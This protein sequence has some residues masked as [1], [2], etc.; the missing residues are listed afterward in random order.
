MVRENHLHVSDLILPLFIEEDLPEPIE[1]KSMPGVFRETEKTLEHK[2]QSTP[3][4]AVLK[5][6]MLFGVSHIIKTI[7]EAIH[8]DP[9]GLAR[10]DD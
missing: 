1:I 3:P 5:L 2:D 7:M 9:G 10:P 8:M 6:I 4:P